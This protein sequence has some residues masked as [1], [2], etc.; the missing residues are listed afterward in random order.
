MAKHPATRLKITV[1]ANGTT[2]TDFLH[3]S[4]TD[5]MEAGRQLHAL[6]AELGVRTE[7]TMFT[8]KPELGAVAEQ[9]MLEQPTLQEGAS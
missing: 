3:F 7:I 1:A 2:T 9:V 5:C 6:L 4:G 8:P